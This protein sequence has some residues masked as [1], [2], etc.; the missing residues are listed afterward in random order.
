[1]FPCRDR[2]PRGGGDPMSAPIS[3]K[4]AYRTRYLVVPIMG[5]VLEQWGPGSANRAPQWDLL[6]DDLFSFHFCVKI[7]LICGYQFCLFS[8]KICNLSSLL[9]FLKLKV[10]KL[11]AKGTKD[12]RM[13]PRKSESQNQWVSIQ[14]WNLCDFTNTL[15]SF[16]QDFVQVRRQRVSYQNEMPALIHRLFGASA[17]FHHSRDMSHVLRRTQGK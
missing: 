8:K 13:L 4:H 3:M 11:H 2:P 10:D 7:G 17:H 14:L 16:K 1:M 5:F 6:M 12:G 15:R 9:I